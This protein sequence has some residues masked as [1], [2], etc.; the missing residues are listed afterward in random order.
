MLKPAEMRE[1]RILVLDKDVDSV[2]KRLDALR[3]VHITDIKDFYDE[4][5]GLIEP[6]KAEETALK[7]SE[8]LTRLDNLIASLRPAETETAGI[9]TVGSAVRASGEEIDLDAIE[10]EFRSLEQ[11]VKALT[12]EREKLRDALARPRELLKVIGILEGFGID[13]DFIGEKAFT[14][15]SVGKVASRNLDELRTALETVTGEHHVLVSRRTTDEGEAADFDAVVIATLMKDKEEVAR[16][17]RMTDFEPFHLPL[18]E[19][20]AKSTDAKAAIEL[21]IQQL[22]AEQKEKERALDEI[23]ETR[24]QDL[25]EMQELVAIEESKAKVKALFGASERV[26]VLEGWTPKNEVDAVINGINS[27]VGG[28]CVIEVREPRRDDVRVPTLLKNPKLV[29]P[30]ESIIRMY[31][32]PSYRDIDPTLVTAILFPVLFGLMFPDIGHGFL[33]LLLGAL[34]LFEVK[35]KGLKEWGMIISLCGI[36]AIGGGVLFGEFFGFSEYAAHLVHSSMHM[37]VPHLLH[38]LFIHKPLWFEPIPNVTGMFVITLLIGALHMGLGV[39][40]GVKNKLADQDML[41]TVIEI[42]KIWTLIGALYFLLILLI[43]SV[44]DSEIGVIVAL[45]SALGS[46]NVMQ[47]FVVLVVAPILVLFL[48]CFTVEVKHERAHGKLSFIDFF[49]IAITGVIEAV[50]ENF[51]RFLANTISYGR[52]LALALAHA[53]LIEVFILLTFMSSQINIAFAAVVFILGT[54]IVVI[55]EAI[56][57]GIHAVRLHYYEWF[58]KFY[59]GGG[60]EFTPFKF[61]RTLTR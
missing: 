32:L 22:E 3:N 57:S 36:C 30:F 12:S 47:G 61:R 44:A 27:E 42:V 29:K 23:R 48:L 55:L 41:G 4:W 31:S 34:M 59:H 51:F 20:P 14:A 35:L 26:R 37:E 6:A 18:Q 38:S 58:T 19:L 50:L 40:F 7:A 13:L 33:L 16:A 8:L 39:A 15:V 9:V 2:I 28:L 11:T 43:S 17:L 56:M 1:L 21:E 25:L 46:I 24:L 52:I 10:R 5:S 60:I 54:A 49:I 45:A 53:A